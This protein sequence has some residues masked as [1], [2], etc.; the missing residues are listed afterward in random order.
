MSFFGYPALVI[1]LTL[2]DIEIILYLKLIS[3]LI[4]VLLQS[5]GMVIL[6]ANDFKDIAAHAGQRSRSFYDGLLDSALARALNLSLY[7][8]PDASSVAAAYGIGLAKNH[9]FVDGN[10][11]AAFLA[12]G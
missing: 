12:V 9:A 1:A 4:L 8:T 7:Q 11:R 6:D 3:R 10:K 5:I 2:S